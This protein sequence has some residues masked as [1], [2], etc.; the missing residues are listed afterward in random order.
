MT[1]HAHVPSPCTSVCTMSA[2]T[3]L[4]TGCFRTI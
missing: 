3:G 4:C 2:Q 1:R